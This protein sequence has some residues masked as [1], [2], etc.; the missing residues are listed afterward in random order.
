[1]T[2]IPSVTAAQMREVDRLMVEQVGVSL[3]QMME[4]AGRGLALQARRMLDGDVKGRRVQVLAGPGG[5][6]GGG[7]VAARRLAVWGADVEVVLAQPESRLAAAVA[8]QLATVR[9]MQVPVL[10]ERIGSDADLT[11]DALFGYSLDGPPRGHAAELI[12]A[13]NDSAAR[14]LALDLPSGLHPDTGEA[15]EPTIRA[16][17]TLTLALPK[18][19]LVAARSEQWVGDLYL[20][21]ISVP[22]QV[23]RQIGLE[24]GP[25]FSESDVIR[26]LSQQTG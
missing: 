19:G 20:A 23:Y 6:G 5:N 18:A 16:A 8:I 1:L 7:L 9:W 4:N 17:A 3:L 22:E 2:Q 11:I 24:V 12:E 13:A 15:M 26:L 14:I 10:T 21:D 25:I